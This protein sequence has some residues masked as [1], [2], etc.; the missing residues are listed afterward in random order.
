VSQTNQ[1]ELEKLASRG[2]PAT[3]GIMWRLL[4]FSFIIFF[5]TL[6]AYVGMEFGYSAF[7]EG[8]SNKAK[9]EANSLI[10]G[11]SKEQQMAV[12]DFYS[13]LSN[14]KGLL[15]NHLYLSKFIDILE[16]RTSPNVYLDDVSLFVSEEKVRVSGVART[17]LDLSR[18]IEAWG[19]TEGVSSV[20]LDSSR[21]ISGGRVSFTVLFNL[22]ESVLLKKESSQQ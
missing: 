22:D 13:R 15:D 19:G 12:I 10:K 17:F 2:R 1:S 16:T 20:I 18:Q 8:Q 7:L 14:I 4:V 11:V 21:S 6:G 9:E 3:G 5:G